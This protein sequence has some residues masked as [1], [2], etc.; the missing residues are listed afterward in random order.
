LWE[1]DRQKKILREVADK[2]HL[3]NINKDC[4]AIL[5]E[6]LENHRLKIYKEDALEREQGMLLVIIYFLTVAT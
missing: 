2:L 5:K 4:M 3:D 6:Q 1:Q